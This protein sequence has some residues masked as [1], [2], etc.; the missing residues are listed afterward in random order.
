[1]NLDEIRSFSDMERLLNYFNEGLELQDFAWFAGQLKRLGVAERCGPAAVLDDLASG[2]YAS[3]DE[4]PYGVATAL[5]K[6]WDDLTARTELGQA[7][8]HAVNLRRALH[9]FQDDF[10]SIVNLNT[11]SNRAARRQEEQTS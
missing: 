4:I 6:S 11:A 8:R 1:M 2:R 9:C 10:R 5:I 3:N 7:L